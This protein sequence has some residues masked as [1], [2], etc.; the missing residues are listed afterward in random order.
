METT[1]RKRIAVDATINAPVEKVWKLYTDPFSITKW[2]FASDDWQCTWAENYLRVGGRFVS[3]MEAK[4]G[5]HGFDFSGE[6][7]R[8]EPNKYIE[9]TLDDGRKVMIEFIA[10][11]DT[12]YVHE[13]FEAEETNPADM[14][15]IGWQAIMDN[16]K[17]YVENPRRP[18]KLHFETTI[19]ATPSKVYEVML[20]YEHYKTWTSEFNPSS[21][22]EGSWDKGSKIHFIG[23]SQD[24][25]EE[26]MVSRIKENIPNQ[27]VSIEHRGYYKEGEE[28]TSV[29]SAQDWIGAIEQYTFEEVNGSTLLS[30]DM[31][32]ND[33][34]ND[35]FKE[36]WPR[37]LKSLKSIC[38]QQ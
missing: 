23:V 6:Y 27:L 8:V 5:S 3:R 33:Q 36:A 19:N 13:I 4:D 12:T 29:E 16:F 21:R 14:Q 37:A 20:D 38:E 30:V 25:I 17:K 35:Y 7:T 18:E 11:G 1:E 9:Y 32:G 10:Q 15:K 24:G 28:I 2:N 22:Y 34:Y 26:G 31:D